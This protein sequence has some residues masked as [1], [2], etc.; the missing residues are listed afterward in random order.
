[1]RAARRSMTISLGITALAATAL[2]SCALL[3]PMNTE[4]RLAMLDKMPQQLPQREPHAAT[5]LVFPPV[6][7]AVYDTTRMAYTLRPYEVAYFSHHRWGAK[8]A[9]MLQTQLVRTLEATGYFSA[10]L[11]PPYAGHYSYALRTEILDLVQDFT[12]K[13]ATLQLSLQVRLS[14]DV[15]GHAV[16][17]R[18]LFLREPMQQEAPYA[19]AVAAN[20]AMAKALQEIAAFVLDVAEKAK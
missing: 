9:Q 4:M 18:Q 1:M 12:A 14:D 16:A 13:P 10:V 19:G 3:S 17:T 2:P 11:T 7:K 6:A 20:D 5:L 8:P 15:D